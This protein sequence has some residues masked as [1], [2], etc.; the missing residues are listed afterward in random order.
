ML[1]LIVIASL[2]ATFIAVKLINS[3]ELRAR[4]AY[5]RA[6]TLLKKGQSDVAQEKLEAL[7]SNYPL[8][9]YADDALLKL[10]QAQEFD[11]DIGDARSNYE[12]LISLYPDSPLSPQAKA[13]LA[14]LNPNHAQD[15]AAEAEQ[16]AAKAE[17][18]RKA[19]Q[20]SAE[21]KPAE[22]A[23]T[24]EASPSQPAVADEGDAQP[25]IY[26]VK[27]GD[28]LGKIARKFGT[29][30]KALQE[31]N[32]MKGTFIKR[33]QEL[34]IPSSAKSPPKAGT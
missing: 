26:Q 10:G 22:E 28:T 23:G 21:A 29:T 8:S 20:Q 11:G 3:D 30:V 2:V 1:G 7:I 14:M 13:E 24:I 27:A 17:A 16:E 9:S 31:A 5:M 18:A 15:A 32:G 19:E 6:M 33:D 34:N 12:A 4:T 25:T